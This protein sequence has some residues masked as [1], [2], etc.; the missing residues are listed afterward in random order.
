MFDQQN[1]WYK[2]IF[3]SKR[4]LGQKVKI[5]VQNNVGPQKLRPPKN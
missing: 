2:Q 1:F 4:Y 3:W 5:W